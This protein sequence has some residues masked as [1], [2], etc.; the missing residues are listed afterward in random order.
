MAFMR[1]RTIYQSKM[2]EVYINQCHNAGQKTKLF[3]V[4]RDDKSGLGHLLGR[5]KW[6]GAWRQ[7]VFCPEPDTQWSAG[8]QQGITDFMKLL[9][10]AHRRKCLDRLQKLTRKAQKRRS[11]I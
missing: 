6:S 9:T 5:I 11:A 8:C 7:Y 10:K 1:V 4:R 2:V 3:T